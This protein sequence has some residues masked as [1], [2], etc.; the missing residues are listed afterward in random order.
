MPRNLFHYQRAHAAWNVKT[1]VKFLPLAYQ[2]F[3]KEWQ[4]ERPKPVHYVPEPGR[5][6]KNPET[7]QIQRVENVPIPLRFPKEAH[8]GLWGGEGVI[9]GYQNRGRNASLVPHWWVPSLHRTVL[10]SEVLDRRLDLVVTQRAL[11]LVHDHYGLDMY[12]LQ[13]RACDIVSL[14]G[15]KIKREILL[16][17]ARGTLWP[18]NPEKR[19]ELLEKYKQFIVPE[20]EVEWY[21]LTVGE[22]IKKLRQAQAAA[23]PPPPLKHQYRSELL[24]R[25]QAIQ[26][27]QATPTD[28]E[29]GASSWLTKMNP[30][31]GDK[32]VE[33]T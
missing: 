30:F 11:Q 33:K 23:G 17:L 18:D 19:Q 32:P 7:G 16:A 14:L 24:E 29:S 1:V 4:L 3:Y 15:L 31:G 5:W 10:Y 12:L 6:K 21:G 28:S 26:V 25:L 20:E 8:Q 2:A 9:K 27:E 22:A 13:T